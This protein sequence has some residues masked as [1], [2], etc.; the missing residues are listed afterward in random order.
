MLKS[1]QTEHWMSRLGDECESKAESKGYEAGEITEASGMLT[2]QWPFQL[3]T[4]D[5]SG[6]YS[7]NPVEVMRTRVSAM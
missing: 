2:Q 4:L 5:A 7:N 6:I 1:V 3:S